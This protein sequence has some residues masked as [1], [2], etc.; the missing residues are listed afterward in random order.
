MTQQIAF[1]LKL[2]GLSALLVMFYHHCHFFWMNQDFCGRLAHHPPIADTPWIAKFLESLPIN[3]G[4]LGVA[5]FFLISGFLMPIAAQNKPR[6]EFL[7]RRIWRIWPVYVIALLLTMSLI[8]VSAR[9]NQQL[10]S[11]P[12]S[13]DHIAASLFLVRDLGGYPFIDG[14]VWTLEIEIKFYLLCFIARTWLVEK[15]I[16]FILLVIILAVL[17][18]VLMNCRYFIEINFVERLIRIFFKTM[19][20][21]C[22]MGLGCLL[23][24]VCQ[25]KIITKKA[26]VYSLILATLYFGYFICARNYAAQWK[27]MVSYSVAYLLF[28]TCYVLKEKFLNRGTMAYIGKISYSLYLV[29]GVPGFVVIYWII[30][31]DIKPFTAIITAL[32]CLLF[33]AKVFYWLV[34]NNPIKRGLL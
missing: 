20:Y 9:H 6:L 15:P 31:R 34:E 7:Q 1:I 26:F 2:R 4:N 25:K 22:F 28:T 13:I 27:E 10:L 30:S 17:S 8:Y 14:I 23:S 12:W 18:L 3:F 32:F 33:I 24:Y 21:I 11:F 19:K 29:H 5:V 16:K